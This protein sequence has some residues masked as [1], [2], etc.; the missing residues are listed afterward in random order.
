MATGQFHLFRTR[1]FAPLFVAQAL[2]AFNDNAF[3]AA[4]A[5]FVTYELA[6]GAE[7]AVI[8]TVATG[9]FVLPFFLFS[10]LAGEIA[11][12]RDKARLA[13]LIKLAEIGIMAFAAVSL[14]FDDPWVM[15]VFLFLTGAQSAFFGP[16]KYALLPQHLRRDELL[17][18]N[19][20]I[21]MGTFVS[22]LLG[23]M[24]GGVLVLMEDGRTI[25]GISTVVLAVAGYIAA[26]L[27]PDAP[28]SGD[29]PLPGIDIV[30]S[31]SR[32]L[33]ETLR[34]PHI[35]HAILGISWFWFLGAIFLTELPVL[36]R[37]TLKGDGSVANFLVAA[38]TV[39]IGAGSLAANRLLKGE[40]ST[41]YVAVAA[42]LLT[43][44]LVELY[45]AVHAEAFRARQ[46]L[47][48]IAGFLG[49]P[50]GARVFIDLML[51]SFIA[52]LYVVPLYAF[53]QVRTGPPRRARVI[54]ANNIVN[55]GFMA[56]A[57]GLAAAGLWAGLTVPQLFLA[58]ALMNAI[59]TAYAFDLQ[60]RATLK[61]LM[62]VWLRLLHGVQVHGLENVAA[63][64][65]R[66]VVVANQPSNLDATLLGAF[67][68]RHMA[69]ASPGPEPSW[70]VRH[71]FDAVEIDPANPM[72]AR[73]LA[74]RVK[75]AGPLLM[76]PEGGPSPTGALL[77]VSEEPA[78]VAHLAGARLL[79]VR[80]AGP[81]NR[82]RLSRV[83]LTVLPP[84]TLAPPE[85]SETR[86][87]LK[88]A[89]DDLMSSLM[90]RSEPAGR[91]LV[92]ALIGAARAHGGRTPAVEDIQRAPLTYGRLLMGTFV[93][94]RRLARETEG[95]ANVAVLLP[96]AAGCLV[97]IMGLLAFGRVPALLNYATGARNMA[98]ACATAGTTTLV[99]SRKFI[100]QGGFADDLAVL[101]ETQRV[102]YLEDLREGLTGLDKL[103]GLRARLFPRLTLK[104]TRAS[105]DPDKAAI[106]LFTSGSEGAPK[107]VVLSHRNLLANAAQVAGRIDFSGSD[108][109]FNALPMF[110]AL[111]LNVGTLLPVLYGVRTFLYP[112]PLHYKIIPTLCYETGST[113]LLSTDTFLSGYARNADPLD[114]RAMRH[115]V[116]GAEPVKAETRA[117][118]QERFGVRIL[119]GYGCT[120]CSPV[121]ASNTPR[122][123]RTGSVGRVFDG[124][125]HRLEP[126]EGIPDA[127]RLHVRGPNVMLGY[128]GAEEPG[129]LKVPPDGWHDT[130]DMVLIDEEGFLRIVGRLK[131]FAKVGGEMVPLNAVEAEVLKEYPMSQHAVV[132]VPDRRKG[133]QLVLVTTEPAL[134]RNRLLF[135]LRTAGLTEMMIPRHVI[136]L[137]E[138]PL[139]GSGK[140]NYVALGALARERVLP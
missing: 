38:F 87:H 24:F 85:K 94:G 116:A 136:E 106:I 134:D 64:G 95:Q 90:F 126:V 138:L 45:F 98:A 86:E 121:I 16:I 122:Y 101:A 51:A 93:L 71:L 3:K 23:T 15:I 37:D 96:T 139:L 114:F 47:T 7:A 79:P 44:V 46:A 48:G 76:F 2:G 74:Q 113:I 29:R 36:A 112:S 89:L 59:A 83:T 68:P 128:L 61:L 66:A 91:H 50:T 130:G 82:S 119:E 125:E 55:S 105:T 62:R 25:V 70:L 31:T 102:L 110:H 99:T 120:E 132:A 33:R 80:I 26:R 58:L 52:G 117:L 73:T 28:P 43:L 56:L 111:G 9:L 1:R 115:V 67:L 42:F 137:P 11:D 6:A 13:R 63:A 77:K 30:R 107:G 54:A 20:L 60:P 10:G 21:E 49:A 118:W 108:V 19:G 17:A 88:R 124:I 22:I 103:Y 34:R 41:R 78:V 81:E 14:Q 100:E 57:A 53:M 104:A 135:T 12:A 39:G 18:G 40:I 140:T 72:S 4:I 32:V 97:T 65:R 27:I 69:L 123:F 8:I 127:G 92:E 84:V 35:R 129:V 5:L 75:D 109:V 133:E 131:R